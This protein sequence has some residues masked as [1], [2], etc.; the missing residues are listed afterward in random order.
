MDTMEEKV[1]ELKDTAIETTQNET[2]KEKRPG[3]KG[4]EHYSVVR[5]L[6]GL[7]YV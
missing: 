4:V 6:G 5:Q 2:Q 3:K 7:I 1:G